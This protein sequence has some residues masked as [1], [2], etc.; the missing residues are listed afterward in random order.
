MSAT[1]IIQGIRLP[2][3][4]SS[5]QADTRRAVGLEATP[6]C[7]LECCQPGRLGLFLLLEM[8]RRL[9]LFLLLEMWRRLGLCLFLEPAPRA[10]LLARRVPCSPGLRL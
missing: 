9:R 8:W 7:R 6:D 5:L 2:P 4:R 3:G 10:G 1:P